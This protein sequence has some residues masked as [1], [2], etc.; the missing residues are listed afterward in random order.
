TPARAGTATASW[1]SN[2]GARS[3]C[4][5]RQVFAPSAIQTAGGGICMQYEQQVEA[6]AR[7]REAASN[8]FYSESFWIRTAIGT[9]LTV[10]ACVL[11]SA[12]IALCALDPG[13]RAAN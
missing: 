4:S 10:L 2:R 11:I 12:V 9:A 3:S 1:A 13:I 5:P 6:V 7:V 8:L